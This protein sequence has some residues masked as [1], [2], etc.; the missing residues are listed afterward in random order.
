MTVSSP[1]HGSEPRSLVREVF[2]AMM[3]GL[4][5]MGARHAEAKAAAHMK[6]LPD[7]VLYDLGIHR[8]EIEAVVR[9]LNPRSR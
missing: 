7:H 6:R 3:D 2:A 8:S 4:A 5:C 1:A 9:G